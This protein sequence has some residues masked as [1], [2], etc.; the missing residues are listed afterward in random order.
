MPRSRQPARESTTPGYSALSVFS[1]AGGLDLGFHNAGFKLVW[2]IDSDRDAVATY[3]GNLG[4]HVVVG[5]LPDH[6]LP[7]ALHPDVV[8]G[9]PPCQGFSVAGRMDPE[10][11]RSQHVLDFLDVVEFYEPRAFCMENVSSLARSERWAA[12]RERL[13]HRARELEYEIEMMVLNAADYGVPQ[14]RERMFLVGVRGGS[15]LCPVP[16]TEG[17][18]GTVRDALSLLPAYG[19]PGNDTICPAKVVPAPRPVMRPSPYR[20]SLLFNGAGRVLALDAP[21]RTLPAAMGGNATPIID[22]LELEAGKPPWVVGYHRRL[23]EGRKPVLKAPSRMRRLTAEEA[24]A[25]Q[26]FPREWRFAGTTG[27][28]FRQIGNAVPPGLAVAVARSVRDALD[29]ASV[30]RRA[31]PARPSVRIANGSAPGRVENRRRVG[32]A[33]T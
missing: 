9:G 30:R 16:T 32:A 8:I 21:A 22:Q 2:A 26:T 31:K 18:Q 24:A 27:S 19:E 14:A 23:R 20:G 11:P 7:A 12:V 17:R 6:P 29:S 15:P 3:K 25:L 1:G 13:L 33:S 28:R 4:D 10:D 5:E